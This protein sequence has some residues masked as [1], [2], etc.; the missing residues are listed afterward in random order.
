MAMWVGL[1][2]VTPQAISLFVTSGIGP[3]AIIGVLF[4]AVFALVFTGIARVVARV[5]R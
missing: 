1:A 4:F 5:R 3:L 2:L